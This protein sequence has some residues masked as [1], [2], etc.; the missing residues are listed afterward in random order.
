[1][2]KR[3][4][5]VIAV[6]ALLGIAA[7]T[8]A[9]PPSGNAAAGPEWPVDSLGMTCQYDQE[10]NDFTIAKVTPGSPAEAQGLKEGDVVTKI[11]GAAPESEALV[12]ELLKPGAEVKLMVT[13]GGAETELQIKV[14][15]AGAAKPPENVTTKPPEPTL[16]EQFINEMVKSGMPRAKAEALAKTFKLNETPA[17]SNP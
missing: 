11:N 9:G 7:C 16:E 17:P 8:S 4:V 10:S 15:E 12:N 5:A 14:P 6:V 13:R 3:F 2:I 1:M